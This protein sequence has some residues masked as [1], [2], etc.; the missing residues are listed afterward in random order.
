M[1]NG[2]N[3]YPKIRGL[4]HNKILAGESISPSCNNLSMW[5]RKLE[6][7]LVPWSFSWKETSPALLTEKAE[8]DDPPTRL[9]F[10]QQKSLYSCY[11]SKCFSE[12]NSMYIVSNFLYTYFIL[13]GLITDYLELV[14]V[15]TDL[16][17]FECP[18]IFCYIF[19][20]V[21]PYP[22]WRKEKT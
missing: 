14:A 18:R 10:R 20:C 15:G 7:S 11:L 19:K 8:W 6:P 12:Q 16:L 22:D 5:T 13:L 17:D 1:D 9:D 3:V 21:L 2:L 4:H